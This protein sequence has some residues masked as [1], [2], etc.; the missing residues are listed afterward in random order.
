[1]NLSQDITYLKN[2]PFSYK[3]FS[4]YL[5]WLEKQAEVSQ[6][7]NDLISTLLKRDDE[8]LKKLESLLLSSHEI[9]GLTEK[10][11]LSVFGFNNDL[12]T[13][14]HEKV[15]DILAEPILVVNMNEHGFEKIKKLPSFIKHQGSKIACAD[16]TAERSGKTYAIELKTV[17]ME[18]K[19]KPVPGKPTGN[20]LIPDWW[21]TM[22]RNN[23]VT[24]IEDK[25]QRVIKQL[26]N[27]KQHF[28]CDYTM[29]AFY[30]RRIGSS[31]LMEIDGYVKIITEIKEKY[32]EIDF[33]F[34]KDYFGQVL[35]IPY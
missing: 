3:C 10:E 17:R 15:H 14:D 20:S 34:F 6:D 12:L 24:K 19:P 31:T 4:P 29:L 33:V 32:G 7:G 9:L 5:H 28:S 13:L 8:S 22:F 35:V 16:F 30:T 1:M 23:L 27:T 21:G 26:V 18:N 25:K 2:F 11:F